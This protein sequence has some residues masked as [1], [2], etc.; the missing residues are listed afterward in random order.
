[1]AF[2][3]FSGHR[4]CREVWPASSKEYERMFNLFLDIILLVIPLLMLAVT[5]SL[6]T[7]TLWQGIRTEKAIKKHFAFASGKPFINYSFYVLL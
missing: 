4:K 3:F 6:I 2:V 7:K 5:Y 1:M